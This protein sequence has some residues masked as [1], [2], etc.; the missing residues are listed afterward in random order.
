MS[1]TVP[2]ML[3][4]RL[5]IGTGALNWLDAELSRLGLA[6]VALI[7]DVGV[8]AAGLTCA[9]R[10]A[11]R[12]VHFEEWSS[13]DHEPSSVDLLR[14]VAFVRSGEFDGVVGVGGGSAL[15]IAKAAAA[16]A[17]A[18]LDVEDPD[19]VLGILRNVDIHRPG[20][21]AILLPTT[22]GTGSEVSLNAIFLDAE[23]GRKEAIISPFLLPRVAI[24]DP[25]MTVT[26]PPNVTASAGMD[27]LAHA[28]ESYVSVKA[29][30][31]TSMYALEAIRLI[32]LNLERACVSGADL[33]AREGMALGSLFAGISMAHAG[34]CVG[35][36][37]AYPLGETHHIAHG[38]ANG[39]LLPYAM[40]LISKASA[41][42]LA[43]IA[44]VAGEKTDG[45]SQDEAAELAV[46]AVVRLAESVRMPKALVE[47]GIGKADV[48]F[49]VQDAL[50]V[51]RLLKNSPCPMSRDSVASAF[52]AALAGDVDLV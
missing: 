37:L 17:T 50:N 40:R 30:A 44:R 36:A 5:Y 31:H 35:H 19:G 39:M 8:S 13:I 38:V 33:G 47:L 45:I 51:R 43:E 4:E 32:F 11:A 41:A 7:A 24:A 21:P 12:S 48:P 16:L 25:E 23:T 46:G 42:R 34:T 2:F 52:R 27:A 29:T 15:D 3:P 26:A 14:C 1:V 18:D 9:V 49:L 6:R 28:V 20:L 10:D 22:S